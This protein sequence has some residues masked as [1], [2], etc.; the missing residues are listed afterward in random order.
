MAPKTWS[1]PFVQFSP[2]GPLHLRIWGI[3]TFSVDEHIEQYVSHFILV[4]QF[5][6]ISKGSLLCGL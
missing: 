3:S 2:V 4:R 6:V 1:K 5:V